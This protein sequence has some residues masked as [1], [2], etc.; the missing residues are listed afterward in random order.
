MIQRRTLWIGW[1]SW[2]S[3]VSY[4]PNSVHVNRKP[5]LPPWV[6]LN[7]AE[8]WDETFSQHVISVAS[9]GPQ[10]P[11]WMLP[12]GCWKAARCWGYEGT[13]QPVPLCHHHMHAMH[14][15]AQGLSLLA[16]MHNRRV[17]ATNLKEVIISVQLTRSYIQADTVQTVLWV[18]GTHV[19]G[20]CHIL[21]FNTFIITFK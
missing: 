11:F 8:G 2:L 16:C 19:A 6:K 10:S 14:L 15:S 20:E 21:F 13:W 9:V 1:L 5:S 18:H 12:K 3:L 4:S 17:S 7:A